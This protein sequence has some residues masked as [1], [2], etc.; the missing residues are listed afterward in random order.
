[1]WC[2]VVDTAYEWVF[3]LKFIIS[4]MV[5]WLC[6][7]VFFLLF[8]YRLKPIGLYD[9]FFMY[10]LFIYF[11]Y[12]LLIQSNQMQIILAYS[13]LKCKAKYDCKSNFEIVYSLLSGLLIMLAS[14]RVTIP[15]TTLTLAHLTLLTSWA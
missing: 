4:H 2:S 3:S 10:G 15:K 7:T 6:E 5:V 8:L 11:L 9:L 13:L 12:C 1:M 14:Q